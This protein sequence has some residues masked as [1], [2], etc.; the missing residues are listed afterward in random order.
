MNRSQ[1]RALEG[2]RVLDFSIMLAGPYCARMLA[3]VGADVIKIEPPEGDDM[4]LRAPLRGGH[5]T[6]FGQ[7]NAGK[8]SLALDLKQAAAIAVVHRLVAETDV[9]V[10]NFR[11]GVMERLGL[12]YEALRQINPRLVYCSISGYGQSGPKAARA[13]Y[14]MIVQ[15]ESGFDT[16]L[17]HYAG[18][19]DRPA[20]SAIFIADA[21]GAIFG[22]SAIQTALVQ[23]GRTGQGQQIDVALLDCMSNL[24]IY[25]LQEAQFP[26]ASRRFSY[27]S[28]RAS[29]GDVIITPVTE[30][31][32]A[33]LCDVTKLVELR[34]DPQFATIPSRGRHWTLMME[35]VE[36]WTASRT[37]AQVLSELE[38][39][40][41]PCGAYCEPQAQLTDPQCLHRGLFSR[42]TD[43]AGEFLGVNLP[44]RMSG[45]RTEIEGAVP[46]IGEHRHAILNGALG[47]TDGE[48]EALASAGVFGRRGATA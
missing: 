45:S 7:L 48:I 38:A 32:F 10:E 28:V 33:A 4:R 31:N 6:Y 2:F 41:V 34:T 39:G 42:I 43:S 20:A 14:A 17:M 1:S 5:S 23:R 24:L 40:G 22:F 46:G 29:D 44:W 30:R 8:R 9:I 11:P 36:R 12:G 26:Q 16:S 19:R 27:G 21:L 15:A 47:L 18:D 35:I 13:A 3:D 25:E 37:V